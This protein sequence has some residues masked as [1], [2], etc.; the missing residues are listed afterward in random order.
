[1]RILIA[2]NAF[3]ESATAAQ[4]GSAIASGVL[5]ELPDAIVHVVPIADGGDGTVEAWK[6][7]HDGLRELT[8]E[9]TGPRPELPRSRA[10]FV[11]DDKRGTAIGEMASAAG[12][13]LVP[14][15]MRDPY[16]TTTHGVGELLMAMAEEC[17]KVVSAR[18]PCILLGLGGSAT[19]DGGVGMAAALGFR[20]LDA[21]GQS[22]HGP[23]TGSQLESI[24]S[25]VPPPV[26]PL[27]GVNIEALTD[28][29]NPLIG[30]E[31]A[32]AV[33]G[34]QKGAPPWMVAKL[35]DGLGH[36]AT[37]MKRDLG[38]EVIDVPG[39]G[40]AG[41]LGAAMWGFLGARLRPGAEAMLELAD[42]PRLLDIC[43]FAITGEGRFDSSS[44]Q[45]KAPGVL[46][47]WAL[48]RARPVWLI[49]GDCPIAETELRQAGIAGVER[50]LDQA[51]DPADAMQRALE[52][53]EAAG[54]ATARSI[55][56]SRL[57]S[58]AHPT[59]NSPG[60]PHRRGESD[61]RA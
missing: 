43:D 50:L 9:V 41:G 11:M 29:R 52:L 27:P 49:V 39:G 24:R 54:A 4:A 7:M 36:L 48:D 59:E 15:A 3:K 35:E 20:F 2:P 1:M 38:V 25:I 57:R 13:H 22:L 53:L 8:A 42:I 6:A 23:L 40:A 16:R 12:L 32:A 14:P 47:H 60:A 26:H 31:G 17:R 18:H 45:G 51:S 55:R 44:L 33:F 34:P 61:H 56:G 37:M 19:V 30:T 46:V 58:S 5:R 10:S 28:V 21:D